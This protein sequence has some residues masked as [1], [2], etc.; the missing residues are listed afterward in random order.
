MP[1]KDEKDRRR[2]N[3]ISIFVVPLHLRDVQI[4]QSLAW[5]GFLFEIPRMV[6]Y[7]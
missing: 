3:L 4:P 6:Q 1:E 5:V 2:K 7:K